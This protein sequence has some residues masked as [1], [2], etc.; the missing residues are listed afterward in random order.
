M[1]IWAVN[2]LSFSCVVMRLAAVW[3]STTE[4][5]GK[6]RSTLYEEKSFRSALNDT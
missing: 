6:M 5:R 3:Y 2:S 1:K 4:A